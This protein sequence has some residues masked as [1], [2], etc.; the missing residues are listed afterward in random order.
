M[1]RFTTACFTVVLAACGGSRKSPRAEAGPGPA[2]VAPITDAG[3]VV[4]AAPAVDADPRFIDVRPGP[5]ACSP[6]PEKLGEFLRVDDFAIEGDDLW[7][8]AGPPS[9]FSRWTGPIP[10]SKQYPPSR[11]RALVVSEGRVFWAEVGIGGALAVVTIFRTAPDLQERKALFSEQGIRELLVHGNEVYFQRSRPGEGGLAIERLAMDGT[12]PVP[13]STNTWLGL[14]GDDQHL[15]WSRQD[16]GVFRQRFDGAAERLSNDSV[17]LVGADATHVY[18]QAVQGSTQM[19]VRI[20]KTGEASLGGQQ[21]PLMSVEGDGA[22]A[23]DGDFLYE[24]SESGEVHRMPKTGGAIVRLGGLG[25]Y[26]DD[27]YDPALAFDDRNVYFFAG[28]PPP[29]RPSSDNPIWLMRMCK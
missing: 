21:L 28:P 5:V 8:L 24:T 13:I 11:G 27:D 17:A 19:A 1:R 18:G 12:A 9:R 10:F 2:D 20:R 4:E 25:R 23:V 14:V 6:I 3:P 26:D 15:Y 22:L 16:G 7:I 29:I